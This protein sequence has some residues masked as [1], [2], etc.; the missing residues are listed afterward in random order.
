MDLFAF[1]RKMAFRLKFCTRTVHI[2]LLQKHHRGPIT[3][4]QSDGASLTPYVLGPAGTGPAD[5]PAVLPAELTFSPDGAGETE[6]SPEM[7][8]VSA[9]ALS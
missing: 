5:A 2:G 8:S 6:Y 7:P 4:S 3:S 9:V 1:Y